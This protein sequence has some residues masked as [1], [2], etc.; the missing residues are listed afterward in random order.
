MPD[1]SGEPRYTQRGF[2]IYADDII[3]SK[4]SKVSVVQSSSAEDDCVWIFCKNESWANPD[5]HLNVEQARI[6]RDALSEFIS[7]HDE[8]GSDA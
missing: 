5:P 2:R 1:T 3:D 6:V 7:D 4:G 8:E